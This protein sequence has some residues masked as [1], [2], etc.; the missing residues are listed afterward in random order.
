VFARNK[1][2]PEG[3][4]YL[5]RECNLTCQ[6]KWR[7]DY[8]ERKK[9]SD[10]KYAVK[11]VEKRRAYNKAYAVE[12]RA[13]HPSGNM[14]LWENYKLTQADYDRMHEQ[15]EGR[16]AICRT[17]KPTGRGNRLH[18]DHCHSTDRIRGLVCQ[19]CNSALGF[20]EYLQQ[21]DLLKIAQD[22]LN[23]T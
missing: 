3:R 5:C 23:Q 20:L 1:S 18:V 4:S 22:Y 12:W 10:K 15:Q 16:C 7:N 14:S 21:N 19:R 17:D 2:K 11:N 13:N 9:A 8:P 6:H